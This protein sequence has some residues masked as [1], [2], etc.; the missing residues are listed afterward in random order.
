MDIGERNILLHFPSFRLQF[1]L[2]PYDAS[3][4]RSNGE[5]PKNLSDLRSDGLSRGP[6]HSFRETDRLIV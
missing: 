1:R 3:R 6:V 2:C 5:P 4:R